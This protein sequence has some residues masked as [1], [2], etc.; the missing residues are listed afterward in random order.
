[1]NST[2]LPTT[3]I[4]NK[5]E[6]GIGPITD[7]LLANILNRISNGNFK[8]LLT[9]KIVEPITGIINQKIRPYIYISILLYILVIV[10]LIVIIYL[11]VRS[12]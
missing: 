3:N 10:L 1:M 2:V 11:L 4:D 12:R 8:E 6:T 7:R 5:I 9:D